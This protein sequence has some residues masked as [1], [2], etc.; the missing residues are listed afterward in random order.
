MKKQLSAP[1]RVWSSI[2]E[3]PALTRPISGWQACFNEFATSFVSLYRGINRPVALSGLWWD[4]K[5]DWTRDSRIGT[6]GR[7]PAGS[8]GTRILGPQGRRF[9]ERCVLVS[10]GGQGSVPQFFQEEWATIA[11]AL[12]P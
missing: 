12:L 7:G 1:S 8:W 3:A 6:A 4:A 10:A 9:V 2:N 5:G 11:E